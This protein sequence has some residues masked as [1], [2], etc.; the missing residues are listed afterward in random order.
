MKGSKGRPMN[1]DCSR[2]ASLFDAEGM[3]ASVLLRPVKCRFDKANSAIRRN[4]RSE[5]YICENPRS[6]RGKDVNL[7]KP[8]SLVL[9]MS[10]TADHSPVPIFIISILCGAVSGLKA[11]G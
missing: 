3:L 6:D 10:D 11:S 7:V 2:E 8:N 9:M 5:N 1:K 4:P